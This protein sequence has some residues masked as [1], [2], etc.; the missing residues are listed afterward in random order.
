MRLTERQFKLLKKTGQLCP[1]DED[2]FLRQVKQLFE[3]RG[4]L[5][6]H[7][8][9]S[10]RS[11]AG[12]PDCTIVHQSGRTIFAELKM[13]DN[14]PTPEQ[15]KW[16]DA[17]TEGNEVYLWYPQDW[18]YIEHVAGGRPKMQEMLWVPHGS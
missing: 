4:W 1:K 6:Y 8:H 9:R 2:A 7:T 15:S 14:K 16:L 5:F 12:F 3:M 11:E 17:L 13:P 18:N 10:D